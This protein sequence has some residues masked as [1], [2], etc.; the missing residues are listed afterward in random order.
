MREIARVTI[1]ISEEPGMPRR[2]VE[3]VTAHIRNAM[4]AA[5]FNGPL[6]YSRHEIARVEMTDAPSGR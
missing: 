6:P 1:T 4:Q 3:D 2:T 5:E